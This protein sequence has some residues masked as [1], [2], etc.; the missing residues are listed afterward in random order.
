MPS[1]PTKKQLLESGTN[2]KPHYQPYKPCF[3]SADLVAAPV[4]TSV[5]YSKVDNGQHRTLNWASKNT[6]S[7]PAKF[8]QHRGQIIDLQLI[9]YE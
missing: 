2:S 3:G 7:K 8:P 5:W 6:E 1:Q 9:I 4:A